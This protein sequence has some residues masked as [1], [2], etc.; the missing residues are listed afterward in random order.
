[1]DLFAI[2]SASALVL[3]SFLSPTRFG[4]LFALLLLVTWRWL[5]RGWRA[6]GFAP[7]LACAILAT[8]WGANALVR[9]VE[10]RYSSDC[11]APVPGTI[12]LLAGGTQRVARDETDVDA[13]SDYSLRRTIA[14]AALQREDPESVLVI[15]GGILFHEMEESRLMAHFA[16]RLGVPRERIRIEGESRTTWQNAQKV[17]EMQPPIERRIR[18][19]TSNLHMPRAKYAF[20]QWGFEV[21][22]V[23]AGSI[24]GSG[25]RIG[26]FLP[27]TSA[28]E[29]ADAAIHEL[30]GD[31]AYRAGWLRDPS[32]SMISRPDE[33]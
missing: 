17:A 9:I 1:L 3:S 27:S 7:L 33:R 22:A 11:T 31:F 10:S 4:I 2:D 16:E 20:E 19:V 21:C 30:I 12:V 29:K 18:L 24:Y 8:P 26:Y 6:L 15:S 23:G 32:R 28:L 14:A 5:P 25:H 13:L